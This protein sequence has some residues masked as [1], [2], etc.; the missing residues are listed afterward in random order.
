MAT[1]WQFGIL[2]IAAITLQLFILI[3]YPFKYA[4]PFFWVLYVGIILVPW[5]DLTHLGKDEPTV[6]NSFSF[7]SPVIQSTFGF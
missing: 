4:K 5:F 6:T 7:P 2:A 1:E 3:L